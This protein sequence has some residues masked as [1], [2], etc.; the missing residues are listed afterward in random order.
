MDLENP[1]TCVC[2]W[3]RE[4]VEGQRRNLDSK[5]LMSTKRHSIS[6]SSPNWK[7]ELHVRKNLM[8]VANRDSCA[9]HKFIS[10]RAFQVSEVSGIWLAQTLIPCPHRD[11]QL[12]HTNGIVSIL[13]GFY[14]LHALVILQFITPSEVTRGRM[15]N[16]F[17]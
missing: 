9:L 6:I 10:Y 5:W 2:V 16:P 8:A 15:R 11:Q 1:P 13:I 7:H 14:A 4:R 3:E 17:W 12:A